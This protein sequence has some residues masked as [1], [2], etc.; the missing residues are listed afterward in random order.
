MKIF[1]KQIKNS[2]DL[3]NLIG[4]VIDYADYGL[5]QEAK[6]YSKDYKGSFPKPISFT[7]YTTNLVLKNICEGSI[8]KSSKPID[9]PHIK[10]EAWG[11]AGFKRQN[12]LLV[13]KKYNLKLKLGSELIFI[14][15]P[16]GENFRDKDGDLS[17]YQCGRKVLNPG[18]KFPNKTKK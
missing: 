4:S 6:S 16:C 8:P 14:I 3:Y 5:F 12:G 17:C 2:S 10:H 11:V 13:H 18:Y 9:Y 1:N 15:N 7:P